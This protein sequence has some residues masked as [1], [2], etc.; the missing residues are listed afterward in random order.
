[1]KGG[2][3]GPAMVSGDPEKSLFIEAVRQTNPKLKMPMGG[4]L[5][6][7]EI[8]DLTAWVKAG[9][10]WPATAAPVV[11]PK[12]G[13]YVITPEQRGFWSFQPLKAVTAPAPANA[14]WAKTDIDRFVIAKLEQEGLK[15]VGAANKRTLIRRATLDLTGLPPTFEEIEAFE[16]DDAPDAFA[17]VVDRLLASEQ[18][19]ERWGRFWLDVARYGEDDYRSLDPMRR[20]YNPYPNAY[21]YRDWV[22]KAL[23]EDVPFD[24]FV[25]AQLAADLMDEKDRAKML[26]ALGFLGQGPW[27]YDNGSVEVTRADERHDRVDVVSRGFLGLTVG[28]ARCHNHKYDPIPT[29][30]YYALSGVFLNTIYHE[31]PM[32]PKSVADEYKKTEKQ[33]EARE[34]LL[35]DF[36]STESKQLGETLAFQAAKYM[37]SAWKVT[38]P[39][40]AEFATVVQ[41]DK[42]DYE[43]FERWI[44]FLAKPPKNYPY[45]TA[46]QEM[47]K[48]GGTKDE[49]KKLSEEFQKTLTAV[50]FEHHDIKDENDIIAAKALPTT[51]KRKYANLPNEFVTND[52]FCPGCGLELRTLPIE[53]MNLWLDVFVRDLNEGDD[54]FQAPERVKPGLLAFRGWGLERQLSAE[55]RAYIDALKADIE[56]LKKELPPHF[57]YVHGVIEAEKIQEPKVNLRGSPF[58]L[59]DE[60]PRHFLSVLNTEPAPLNHGSGRL[61]LAEQIVQQPLAMRV[62]VNRIWRAHFG[63]GIVDTPSNFG[64][65]GERPSNPD[66]LEYLAK[67]FVDNGMSMKKLHREILLSSVYQLSDEGLKEN[68]EKDPANRLYWRANRHR[69]DAEQIRDSIL[70]AA[71]DLDTKM[72]GPSEP[73]KPE[74]TRR[75]VYGKVSRYRLDEYLQLFDFPSPNLSAEKRF[76][77]TVPLQRLFFMN[78]DFV[79]QQAEHLAQRVASEPDNTARIQKIYQFVY[80]RAAS[81]EEVRVGIEYL[82][83]EPLKEYEEQKAEREKKE[84]AEKEKA[85]KTKSP[86]AETATAAEP[87]GAG[88]TSPEEFGEDGMM[89]G[90][91]GPS[92]GKPDEKKK[93]PL[94]VTPWGRYAKVLLSSSEFL[95]VN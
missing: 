48:R 11:A 31:Y 16:K 79:Q 7:Q 38:G 87:P 26:P 72:G 85:D 40:K 46:W 78:S 64:I 75:T 14:D 61:D 92:K 83:T 89:A 50:L 84:K 5:K 25:K 45:L 67:W 60:V 41:Q 24:V 76:S 22:I 42:L 8:Q 6:E 21:L 15:P 81:P 56:A 43:L 58:N 74:Y 93:P 35:D 62:I 1:M 32:V 70:A 65:M 82:R 59:G 69:M 44:K 52:D 68:L 2:K 12:S 73:L 91:G 34:E 88:Q 23:N 47:I 57:P 94:P 4:K 66:L 33:I 55:R 17:K 20:G 95:F 28:C 39:D 53:R 86:A 18:Y 54:P 3:S 90:M 80:G 19:G 30:D 10:I 29:K 77:T 63:S 51:K 49:A 36:S 9:A 13:E 71:G 37:Q 27:F